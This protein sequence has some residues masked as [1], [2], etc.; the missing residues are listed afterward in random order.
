M[1]GL[2]LWL[3]S[4]AFNVGWYRLRAIIAIAGAPILLMPRR[5]V[6]AWAKAVDYCRPVVAARH[7][8]T[9]VIACAG[10]RTCQP[11]R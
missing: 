8:R 1:T 2:V 5:A 3:R 7:L 6:V 10:W 11:G 4:L 9:W